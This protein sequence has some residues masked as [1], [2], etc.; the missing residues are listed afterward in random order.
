MSE[1]QVVGDN[2]FPAAVEIDRLIH[3]PARLLIM[4]NLH[5]VQSADFTFL[6][7]RTGLTWGNLSSHLNKLDNAGYIAVEKTYLGKRPYT[8][9]SLSDNGRTAF[10]TYRRQMQTLLANI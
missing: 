2:G 7:T 9:L 4:A 6:M 1:T 8:L 10:D 3:E 5:V